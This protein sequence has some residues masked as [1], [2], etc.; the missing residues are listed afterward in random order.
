MKTMTTILCLLLSSCVTYQK[1]VDKYGTGETYTVT[2]HDTIPVEVPVPVPADS[3]EGSVRIQDVLQGETFR[4]STDRLEVKFWFDK[5]QNLLHYRADI[6]AD[7]II[8]RDTVEIQKEVPCPETEVLEDTPH[9]IV[10]VW[11]RYKSF[12]A[13]AL[14]L[15]L[16]IFWVI[17]KR[18]RL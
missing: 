4:D 12:A 8:V 5:Y 2:V 18:R 9:G 14:L 17:Y 16:F 15:S 7:T 13:Y 10:G 6:K 11:E 1:C 3:V